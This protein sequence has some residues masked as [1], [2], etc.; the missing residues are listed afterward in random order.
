VPKKS[1]GAHRPHSLSFSLAKEGRSGMVKRG[2]NC[3]VGQFF[4]VK[5]AHLWSFDLWFFMQN[6]I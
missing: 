1:L 3:S 4:V 6:G 5:I 2:Q